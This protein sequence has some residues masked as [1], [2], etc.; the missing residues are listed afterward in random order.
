[1]ESYTKAQLL[2]LR[3]NTAIGLDASIK[4]FI[5][6]VAQ[7]LQDNT[8]DFKYI[9]RSDVVLQVIKF[10]NENLVR[11]PRQIIE[12]KYDKNILNTT[13]K[14]ESFTSNQIKGL[15]ESLLGTN[16]IDPSILFDLKRGSMDLGK[17]TKIKQD[18][19]CYAV[20]YFFKNTNAKAYDFIN[21]LFFE[22]IDL[23][24]Q[25]LSVSITENQVKEFL[26]HNNHSYLIDAIGTAQT[27]KKHRTK[28]KVKGTL[29]NYTIAEE[30]SEIG[31]LIKQKAYDNIKRNEKNY[32]TAADKLTTA[33]IFLYNSV[34]L[35]TDDKNNNFRNIF[36]LSNDRN[37]SHDAYTKYINKA[38]V[39]GY[40][41]PI[42][43]KKLESSD[44]TISNGNIETTKVKII[45]V[46]TTKGINEQVIDPFLQKIID[47]LSISNK[48]E[49]IAQ[50]DE[51]IDIKNE[52]I[53]LN[54]YGTR[55]TFDFDAK[56][57][58]G[59]T[60]TYDVFIQTNQIYIKPPGSSSNSGLG[61][62]SLEYIK[63]QIMANLP[64]RTKFFN[65]LKKI[66]S[67]AFGQSFNYQYD[68]LNQ[69]VGSLNKSKA[70]L[71]EIAKTYKVYNRK[72]IKEANFRQAIID[73][74][75]IKNPKDNKKRKD[76]IKSE[77]GRKNFDQLTEYLTDKKVNWSPATIAD[78]I[79]NTRIIKRYSQSPILKY[80]KI[81]GPSEYKMVFDRIDT[82]KDEIAI[83]YVTSMQDN[84]ENI[85][86]RVSLRDGRFME[87][88]F[89]KKG[90]P[91]TSDERE[92]LIYNKLSTM[93]FLYY[94]GS[95][96][97]TVK[98]WIKNALIL[99][100]YGISSASGVIILNGNHFTKNAKGE[101]EL[102]RSG[103]SAI[104]RRNPMYVKIGL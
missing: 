28:L 70:E 47:L 29:V 36:E 23:S 98:K 52:T 79:K 19:V 75:N 67:E 62:I 51:V 33:D 78:D 90:I 26:Y 13:Q 57:K 103:K 74:V 46:A 4:S 81:L 31:N 37:L 20:R 99:G 34:N 16:I 61:G 104:T 71:I 44:L 10:K 63:E 49:F 39:S 89:A 86:R 82:N 76:E 24:D 25:H 6:Q 96:Q 38:L 97:A 27:I 54:M 101:F 102:K 87:E 53:S 12:K 1:M 40:I 8:E 50:M 2:S 72:Y 5:R 85:V 93:E 43:L 95:N 73:S 94:I 41:I 17:A 59:K 83:R 92:S 77:I 21:H 9:Q 88:L 45:N 91:L 65:A 80:S 7:N 42:S 11:I 100:I 14:G 15:I 18:F 3:E 35:P 58:V 69:T 68:L 22:N 64:E 32:Y 84:V 56:F 66:R 55:S 48:S 30:S 60:E